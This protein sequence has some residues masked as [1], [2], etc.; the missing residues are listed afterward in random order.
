MWAAASRLWGLRGKL[1]AL[2]GDRHA[3]L[4]LGGA[5]GLH[6]SPVPC[7]KNLLKKFASKTKKKFW[8]EGPSLGSHLAY[9]PSQ[10]EFLTKSTSKKTKKEDHVR[11][12]ALNGLLYKALT[13]LLC[14]PEVS[15]EICDLNVELSKVSLTSDF[16]ACR[17]YWKTTLSAEQ[18][19]HTEAALQRSAAHMRLI[20]YWQLLTLDPQM[21]K[22]TLCTVISGTPRPRMPHRC[23]TLQALQC[24]R[25]CV[26]SITRRS[27]SRS[28][29]TRGGKRE[30]MG[31]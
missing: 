17:V 2:L 31:V 30:R 14:T 9:K 20:G 8:Y 16:S 10:L 12:R 13:D 5:Q 24:T 27:T 15:Q 18:N 25:L 23:A 28:W 21:K 19:A 3:A 29:S 11:L 1:R 22:T 6:G 26:G 7:G 4:R